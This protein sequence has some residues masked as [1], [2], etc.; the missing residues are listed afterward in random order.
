MGLL[1]SIE[2]IQRKPEATRYKILV[3][4]VVLMMALIIGLWTT[5][6]DRQKLEKIDVSGPFNILWQNIKTII[7]SDLWQ[8]LK[9]LL[10]E[11]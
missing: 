8:S 5:L 4:S 11:L 9:R 1:E 6:P 10:S 2:K 3:V 7:P